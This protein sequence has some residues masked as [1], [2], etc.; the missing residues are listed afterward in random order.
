MQNDKIA[1]YLGFCVR[2][3]KIAFGMDAIENLK[4]GVFL[5]MVDDGLSPRSMKNAQLLKDKFACPLIVTENGA[6]GE[7]VKRPAVKAVAVREK[8]LASAIVSEVE[9]LGQMKIYLGGTNSN[10]GGSEER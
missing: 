10:Y 1:T 5:L 3:G 8:N 4:K 7:A 9:R 2:S 6:L